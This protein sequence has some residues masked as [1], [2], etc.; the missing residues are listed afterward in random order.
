MTAHVIEPCRSTTFIIPEQI[1]ELSVYLDEPEATQYTVQFFD[2]ESLNKGNKDGITY[3]GARRLT[4][5]VPDLITESDGVWSLK[6]N[7]A[8]YSPTESPM[9]VTVSVML[10]GIDASILKKDVTFKVQLRSVCETTQIET[11]RGISDMEF[12]KGLDKIVT[13]TISLENSKADKKADPAYCGQYSC[14]L[15]YADGGQL[16]DHLIE[17]LRRTQSDSVYEITLTEPLPDSLQSIDV[18]V[19]CRLIEWLQET[20]PEVQDLSEE[21]NIKIY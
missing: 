13:Q 12:I 19:E 7:S 3:C 8:D 17:A 6:A 11:Q 10:A 15:S 21:I 20:Y 14:S 16:P 4:F 5:S 2:T 18:I 1:D 9:E